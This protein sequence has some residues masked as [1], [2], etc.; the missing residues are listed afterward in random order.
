MGHD[1]ELYLYNYDW[2]R[3][4]PPPCA[5]E[6]WSFEGNLWSQVPWQISQIDV[7]PGDEV[8]F[9]RVMGIRCCAF[10]QHLHQY[11]ERRGLAL[12]PA[13]RVSV[14]ARRVP[15]GFRW[16]VVW[17]KVRKFRSS[18]LKIIAKVRHRISQRPSATCSTSSVSMT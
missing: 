7:N 8:I 10:G 15:E 9:L 1:H 11:Q 17:G 6:R 4:L 12:S 13:F 14:T 18:K 5:Y 16:I 3:R 2:I